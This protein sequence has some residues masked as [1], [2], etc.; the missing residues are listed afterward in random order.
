[1]R[2]RGAG[3]IQQDGKVTSYR[4][5]VG[6]I[7]KAAEPA[8]FLEEVRAARTGGRLGALDSTFLFVVVRRRP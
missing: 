5:F 2:S 6:A 4:H 1:L 8:F 7:R 3:P